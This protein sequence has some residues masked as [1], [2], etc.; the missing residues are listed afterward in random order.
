MP[1]QVES[2]DVVPLTPMAVVAC[3]EP[4]MALKLPFVAK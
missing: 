4:E 2:A 1:I 3:H